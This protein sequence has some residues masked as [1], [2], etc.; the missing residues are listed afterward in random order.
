MVAPVVNKPVSESFSYTTPIP[1]WGSVLSKWTHKRSVVQ[2]PP[3]NLI[4]PYVMVSS[5]Y[6]QGR[7]AN[8]YGGS[9]LTNGAVSVYDVTYPP[10]SI[11]ARA[12]NKSYE[13]FR[14]STYT[15][16]QL[17]VAFAESSQSL[18]MMSKAVT[19][20]WQS[21]RLVRKGRFLDAAQ[22]LG[23]NYVPQGV[24][25]RRRWADN[26]LEYHFGWVPF[27]HDVYDTAEVLNNP[28]KTFSKA[29]GRAQED[30]SFVR[31]DNL[32]SV[33]QHWSAYTIVRAQQGGYI[34]A[35]TNGTYHTLDQFGVLNPALVAWELVPFSFVIDWFANIGDVLQSYSDFAGMEMGGTY[36]TTIIRGR[37][38]GVCFKNPGWPDIVGYGNLLFNGQ[39]VRVD[40]V[41][42]LTKPVFSLKSLRLP[43]AER[44]LT[45]VSLLIQQG[46]RR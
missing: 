41:S 46:T 15:R 42:G 23:L 2:Q 26:W 27:I 4:L 25:R 17:G 44:V 32:G 20:I 1:G 43:S 9:P 8:Y 34:K 33:S 21:M 30:Y 35:I 11:I 39:S 31:R 6:R 28:I 13:V 29:R 37:V 18:A 45:A 14:D 10:D 7:L 38:D 5:A 22:R 3:F 16:S 36:T 24:N 40:R 19:S 12:V